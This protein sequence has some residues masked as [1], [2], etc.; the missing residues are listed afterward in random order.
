MAVPQDALLVLYRLG[1][2]GE[3][4]RIRPKLLENQCLR[5]NGHSRSLLSNESLLP[6]LFRAVPE[7]NG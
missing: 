1:R 7:K 4:L 6:K 3:M 5:W 2:I